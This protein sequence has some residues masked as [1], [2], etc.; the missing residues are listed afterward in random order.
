M[1]ISPALIVTGIV[2]AVVLPVLLSR[3]PDNSVGSA[4]KGLPWQIE[5]QPDGSTRVF[6]LVPG[7]S[8]LE[9]ARNRFG[10][11]VETAYVAAPGEPGEIEA[12]FPEITAGAVTGKMIVTA[13]IAPDT[14][15]KIRERATAGAY[16]NSTTRK[17]VLAA[18]DKDMVFHAPIKAIVFVPAINLDEQIVLQRF[19]T[20]AE[21]IRTS[22]DIEHF[23]YRERGLDLILDAKGREVLQYVAPNRF[24]TLRAPLLTK[25]STDEGN[26][27]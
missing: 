23:L 12:Y 5:I 2:A 1:K 25:T 6:D 15:N 19:G 13:D 9:D 7:K 26:A 18:T 20:P 8:S 21:R 16:M 17:W 4:V 10:S 22:E 3:P 27:K 24:E 11:D 14:L